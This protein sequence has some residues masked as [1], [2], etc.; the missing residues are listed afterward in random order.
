[1]SKLAYADIHIHALWG[2]DD[3]ADDR[4]TAM[5]IIADSYADGVRIL[6]LT[7]H[8]HL[9]YFG[10]NRA[11]AQAAFEELVSLCREKY[12]DLKLYLGNEL[13]YSGGECVS[14][15]DE[16]LCRTLNESRYVLVDFS[17]DESSR[18]IV[19]GLNRLLGAGYIPVL[20]HAERYRQLH[21]NLDRI[22]ELRDN[23]VQIQ[24]DTQALLGGYGLRQR[25]QS[26]AIVKAGL[27]DL[28]GSDAHDRKR[29]PPGIGQTYRLLEK[30]Y[31]KKYAD[32]LCH[33][34]AVLLLENETKGKDLDASNG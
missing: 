6:C 3:G 24:I 31:G 33:D 8:F 7:P 22:R 4:N 32:L 28:V 23:G 34:R 30:K 26:R 11:A 9:G 19:G 29:R 18:V 5:D 20:A 15:L 14:W 12:P 27:A 16:G 13:R 25:M 1:M 17:D 21:G 2:C 10:D